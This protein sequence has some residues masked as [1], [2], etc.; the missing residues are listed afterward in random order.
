MNEM[1]KT[2]EPKSD[3]LN[4]DNLIGGRTITIKITKVSILGGDQPV[5]LNYDGDNGKPYKPGKSMRRVIVTV[6]GSDSNRYIGKFLTLYLDD[7]VTYGGAA[8]GGIRISHMSGIDKDV[9]MALTA[10]RASR[11]PYTV[12]PLAEEIVQAD[13]ARAALSSAPFV[14]QLIAQGH[15][16]AEKGTEMLQAFWSN[17]TVQEKNAI[18]VAQ[19][20]SWKRTSAEAK[21]S[22]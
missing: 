3:Q 8:V 2:I 15:E 14:T 6:W 19:L 16:I 1:L 9:T 10:A 17:L 7:K 18:G 21:V 12:K 4:A 5:A 13:I 11:K 20:E 22:A